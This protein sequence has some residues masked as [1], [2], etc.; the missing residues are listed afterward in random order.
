[1][2]SRIDLR[3]RKVRIF[4]KGLKAQRVSRTV[5]CK[6]RKGVKSRTH[7]RNSDSEFNVDVIFLK[8]VAL[9]KTLSLLISEVETLLITSDC[10]ERQGPC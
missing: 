7:T 6:E 10:N 5:L 2:V 1:M 4:T 8:K 9:F 3:G